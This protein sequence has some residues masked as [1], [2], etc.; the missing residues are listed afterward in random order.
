MKPLAIAIAACCLM[1]C[2]STPVQVSA[3]QKG[4]DRYPPIVEWTEAFLKF[5][6]R[7]VAEGFGKGWGYNALIFTLEWK[8]EDTLLYSFRDEKGRRGKKFMDIQCELKRVTAD[9]PP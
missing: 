9:A 6:S 3:P 5:R 8:D 2:G 4:E 1:A 7:Y